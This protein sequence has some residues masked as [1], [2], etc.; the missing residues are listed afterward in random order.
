MNKS[1]MAKVLS[2]LRANY[3]N[4]RIEN[5]EAMV[6]TWMLTL[7]EFSVQAVMKSAELHM[8]S[9]KFFPTPAELRENIVRSRILNELPPTVPQ[10]ESTVKKRKGIKVPDGMTE[11]EFLESIIQGQIQLETEMY[12]NFLDF[13]R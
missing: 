10:L 5:P 1:D 12:G 2:I 8:K 6:K 7:G 11:D 4:V 9:S 13:E 3:P